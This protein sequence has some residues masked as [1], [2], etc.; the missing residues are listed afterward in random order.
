MHVCVC[1]CFHRF[2][3][4]RGTHIFQPFFILTLTQIM[5]VM[6]THMTHAVNKVKNCIS[7]TKM[8]NPPQKTAYLLNKTQIRMNKIKSQTHCQ[9]TLVSDLL[10]IR[11]WYMYQISN[12]AT[13]FENQGPRCNLI[14]EVCV[15]C[16]TVAQ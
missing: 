5:F 7:A 11:L 16:T 15:H 2:F 13:I 8:A 6:C 4:G 9:D 3:W 12:N 1:H 14:S 10:D